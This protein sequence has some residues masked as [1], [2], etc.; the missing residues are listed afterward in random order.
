MLIPIKNDLYEISD[1]VCEIDSNYFIVF[2]D[3]K[4]K[5]EI[6]NK[7]QKNTYCLTVP[8]KKL[9]ARA[10]DLVQKTKIENA[11]KIYNEIELQNEKLKK[12]EHNRVFEKVMFDSGL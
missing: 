4:N 3:A 1:R 9:D 11:E 12:N 2:N 5:F 10:I 8:Y 6:H 7:S